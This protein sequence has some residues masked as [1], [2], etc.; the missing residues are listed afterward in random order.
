MSNSKSL[1]SSGDGLVDLIEVMR[2]LRDPDSGCPWDVEQDFA[3]IAPYTIEEA[4]EVYD[5][6]SRNDL[7]ELKE[8]LGDLLLQVVFHSQMAEEI[9]A[10]NIQ[11]VANV[12]VE[13]M[14]RRHPH[15]FDNADIAT[16]DAQTAAWEDVKAAE[17]TQ[18]LAMQ[19]HPVSALDGVALALPALLR[20]E[21]LLKRAARTG[22]EW[23][24]ET[25]LKAK[26]NEELQEVEEAA[27]SQDADA[28][29]DE[30]GD[31]LIAAANLARFY[32]VDPE[33]A[34]RR[35][36]EKFER[37]FR[38]MEKLATEAGN[39]FSELSLADQEQLWKQAKSAEPGIS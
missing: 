35:A 17:R 15:V 33:V 22:F 2:R 39:T 3:S 19:D 16:A 6:I 12:I 31:V 25:Y 38:T 13:K 20:A 34:L 24:D 11:D 23:P 37:R 10:F 8:E 18:K 1:K 9:G 32:K 14:I 5:A 4:Y 28:L 29:E 21:K 30:M 26:I 27:R 7:S 36:N